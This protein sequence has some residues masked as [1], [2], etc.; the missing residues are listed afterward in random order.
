MKITFIHIPKTAGTSIH[1]VIADNLGPIVWYP[2]RS[3]SELQE[4]FL[5]SL[6]AFEHKLG[7]TPVSR[8]RELLRELESR[9]AIGGHTQYRITRLVAPRFTF[10]S[11]RDPIDRF[12]SWYFHYVHPD[13]PNDRRPLRERTKGMDIAT[14][15]KVPDLMHEND[16]IM[17]RF[18]A[19]VPKGRKVLPSDVDL[20]KKVLASVDAVIRAPTFDADMSAVMQRLGW[21]AYEPVRLKQGRSRTRSSESDIG[22]Q[23]PPDVVRFDQ[24]LWE[25]SAT[26]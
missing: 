4:T 11:L 26:L 21:G 15:A 1:K 12:V 22:A 20:A 9:P 14:F 3:T 23:V 7:K 10:T 8:Q 19:D 25:F 6:D 5:T 17:V 13:N 24:E 2:P 18:F 16:N